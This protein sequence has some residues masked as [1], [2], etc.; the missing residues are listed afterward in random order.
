MK[1]YIYIFIVLTLALQSCRKYVEIE[2]PG[3]RTLKYTRD[4]RY[5]MDNN[6]E[7]EGSYGYPI[8]SGDDTDITDATRQGNIGDIWPNVLTWREKHLSEIQGDVDWERLYKIIYICNEVLAGVMD[9]QEGTEVEKNRIYAEALVQR[10]I[11]YYT[12]VNMYGK[13]YQAANAATD[14]GVPLLLT[15]NLYASLKRASVAEVYNQVLND[16]VKAIPSLPGVADYNTRPAKVSGYALLARVHLNMRNFPKAELYADSALAL[17]NTLLDLKNYKTAPGTIPRRLLDPE[18][19]LS[20]IVNGSYTAI[21]ISQETL[22]LLGTSDLR[23]TLFTNTRGGYGN[24]FSTAFTG[25]AYWRYTLNGEFVITT[26]PSVPEMMLIKAECRAR[27]E[28]ATGAMIL[29]NNLRA[30]RF[31]TAS[32]LTAVD[33]PAALRVVVE[34]RKREFFGKGF[35][36]FDQKRLNVDAAFAVT[37]TREFKGVT[38]TLAP[39]SNR[40]AY[41]IGDKY[42]LLNPELEQNPR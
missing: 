33:G 22:D 1:K 21:S 20:K 9:S 5:L 37:K 4:Y 29:V 36:W 42:I 2:Q 8:L 10:A 18:V 27:A 19:M 13:Q 30:K 40:Y 3:V 12:L 41:P 28:D 24:L 26:G 35:R 25:R 15:Q 31:E 7:L 14:L 32:P 16:L 34:E 6:G 23:Y 11:S 39:N 38:Y 17:Q